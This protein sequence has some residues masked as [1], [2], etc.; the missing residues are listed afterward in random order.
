M[1]PRSPTDPL[2]PSRHQNHVLKIPDIKNPIVYIYVYIY[3]YIYIYGHVYFVSVLG[4]SLPGSPGKLLW[5]QMYFPATN[6]EYFKTCFSTGAHSDTKLT[7]TDATGAKTQT[8]ST[9]PR[10][11][12]ME[13]VPDQDSAQH[14]GEIV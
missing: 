9:S 11:D 6:R 14:F 1:G 3:I 5:P 10:P 2:C 4:F 12:P 8:N 13:D 7:V